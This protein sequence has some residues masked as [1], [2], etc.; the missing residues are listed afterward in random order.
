MMEVKRYILT[1]LKLHQVQQVSAILYTFSR[2]IIAFYISSNSD[3]RFAKG[4]ASAGSSVY[5]GK[6]TC[7]ECCHFLSITPGLV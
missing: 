7:L 4:I 6:Y 1:S 2:T 3:N 5:V